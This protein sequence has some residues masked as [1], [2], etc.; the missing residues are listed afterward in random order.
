[1]HL[2][3]TRLSVLLLFAILG[4]TITSGLVPWRSNLQRRPTVADPWVPHSPVSRI[5]PLGSS[6][7]PRRNLQK[8]RRRGQSSSS[9]SSSGN[10][11][12]DDDDQ[13]WNQAE[14]RPL[15]ADRQK[16]QGED[17]WM[18]E[19]EFARERERKAAM[20]AREPGQVSDEKLW[21]EVLS[22][23][24]QNWIGFFTVFIIVLVTIVTQFPELLNYPVISIPD[25]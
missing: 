20:R 22:P 7:Q 2:P 23:Y 15:L 11:K 24:K 12:A 6:R 19:E 18:D 25:L 8:R 14:F 13:F 17:Y 1:M 3:S 16:E 9:E 10:T 5:T 4:D 21:G